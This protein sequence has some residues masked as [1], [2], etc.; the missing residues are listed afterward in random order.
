MFVRGGRTFVL[1]A[2]L[3]ACAVTPALAGDKGGGKGAKASATE[4]N[5]ALDM[6][7]AEAMGRLDAA[8]LAAMYVDSPTT[9][10]VGPDGS[11]RMGRGEIQK[12]YEMWFAGLDSLRIEFVQ[13]D[14]TSL[15]ADAVFGTGVVAVYEKPKGGAE[16]MW[17]LRYTDIR[18]KH[19]GKWLYHY[20]QITTLPPDNAS[21]YSRLGGYDALAAVTDDFIG[22][23]AADSRLGRFFG[24]MSKN[25]SNRVRQLVIEQ[26]CAATGGPCIYTGR[27]ARTAHT[28]L[29][30][31]EQDWSAAVAHLVATLDKFHV[32]EREKSEVLAAVGGLKGDIVGR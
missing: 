6:A 21:L 11:A 7:F 1:L 22:R 24:G 19:Q 17:K 2:L 23:L 20:D 15:A 26:L 29:N 31:T 4:E 10:S 9:M 28:G 25:S 27:D 13:S 8:A 3:A 12:G 30:I 14:Y 18:R 32:G 16:K 5:K